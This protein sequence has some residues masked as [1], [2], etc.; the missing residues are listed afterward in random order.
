MVTRELWPPQIL[1]IYYMGGHE[2]AFT[3]HVHSASSVETITIITIRTCTYNIHI[4]IAEHN[5]IIRI[6]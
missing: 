5:M 1:Y 6:L 3:A 2:L 4:I